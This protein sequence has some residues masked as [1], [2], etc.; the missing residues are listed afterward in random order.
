MTDFFVPHADSPEQAERV[1][2]VFIANSGPYP[3]KHPDS[4]LA[5]VDFRYKGKFLTATVGKPLE[6]F[7]EHVGDV[8]GIIDTTELVMIDTV[9][10]GGLSATPILVGRDDTLSRVY[11]DDYPL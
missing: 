9:A 2:G 8:L 11:F 7:P 1:Y 6:G 5:Q 4:R 10:R 3:L